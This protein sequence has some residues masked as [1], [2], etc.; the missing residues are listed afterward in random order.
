ML[1]VVDDL[2][3]YLPS[4]V[5]IYGPISSMDQ[6]SLV[7]IVRLPL[8]PCIQFLSGHVQRAYP[9]RQPS[10][11]LK[12]RLILW[13]STIPI[14]PTPTILAKCPYHR[15]SRISF[16]RVFYQIPLPLSNIQY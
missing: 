16:D 3:D 10:P 6:A 8:Y 9:H 12:H 2:T 7:L 4:H 13:C 14:N 5:G 11:S 15:I 1:F